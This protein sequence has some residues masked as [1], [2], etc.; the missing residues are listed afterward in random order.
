MD[1]GGKMLDVR[2][3]SSLRLKASVD[4]GHTSQTHTHNKL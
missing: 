4:N 3:A 2:E 1:G